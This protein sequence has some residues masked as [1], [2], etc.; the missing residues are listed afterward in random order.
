[1]D[2]DEFWYAAMREHAVGLSIFIPGHHLAS[3]IQQGASGS[4][5]NL[6]CLNSAR[7]QVWYELVK[8]DISKALETERRIRQ[9][10]SAHVSP[11]GKQHR[12]CNAALDKLLAT[13]GDWCQV[14][15]RLRWPYRW[16]DESEAARLRPVARTMIPELFLAPDAR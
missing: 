7:A 15:T 5:S 12:Y 4:Y 14:G 9:F 8:T 13:I 1:M 11:F 16:I 6:A 2:G 3:G 10:M